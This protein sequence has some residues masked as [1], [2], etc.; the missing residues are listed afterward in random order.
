MPS[1]M[2]ESPLIRA[3]A[4]ANRLGDPALVVFDC[5]FSLKEPALGSQK[6]RQAHIP[7]AIYADLD[8]NLADLSVPH[9]GRHPLPDRE[10]FRQWLESCGV[11]DDSLV[12]AYDD[13]GGAFAARL[14]WMARSIGLNAV[15]VLDGGYDAWQGSGYP[16][17]AVIPTPGRGN[18]LQQ[19]APAHVSDLQ[20][21]IEISAGESDKLLL[22][23]REAAR[24]AGE[25]EPLDPVAGHV[26]GALNAPFSGNLDSDKRFLAPEQL[27]SRFQS[28]IGSTAPESVVH[29]CG[30][31]VTA[32]HNVLAME[33]AG[34]HGS[35]LFPGSW[36]QWVDDRRRP[37]VVGTEA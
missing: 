19:P 8:K 25:I 9:R 12:V 34:M 16:L 26:P 10:V 24:Y 27:R 31:G 13:A 3:D 5:R 4:L 17:D 23:A 32:C 29:M 35:R 2:D 22:D 33:V 20:E 37:V 11:S 15:R 6:Y 36:S 18:I 1:N 28:L 14:W 30:S 7:G 21:I